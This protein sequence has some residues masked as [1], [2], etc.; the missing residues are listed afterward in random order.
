M[1]SVLRMSEALVLGLHTLGLLA[2]HPQRPWINGRIAAKLQCSTNTLAKVLQALVRAG[3]VKSRRGPA[4]GFVL[5]RPAAEI[6]LLA[7]YE[8]LEGRLVV[9]GCLLDGKGCRFRRCLLGDLVGRVNTLVQ[10][11]LGQQTLADLAAGM[12]L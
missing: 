7:V 1:K 12:D 6:S 5:A 11:T 4:G 9:G 8:A 3:V 10:D 2:R